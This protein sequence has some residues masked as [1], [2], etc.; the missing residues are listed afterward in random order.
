MQGQD[1]HKTSDAT[2]TGS[3]E[4]QE[5]DY[6]VDRS[7][8]GNKPSRPDD[9]G[10]AQSGCL[11]AGGGAAAGVAGMASTDATASPW[12]QAADGMAC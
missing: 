7:M 8:N 5:L 2:G 10:P 1:Q 11:A 4:E 12:P 6:A 9:C 3:V